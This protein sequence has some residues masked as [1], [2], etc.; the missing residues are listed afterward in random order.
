MPE[1]RRESK[2]KAFAICIILHAYL[3]LV[4]RH[5]APS[6]PSWMDVAFLIPGGSE[7]ESSLQ[8]GR[9]TCNKSFSPSRYFSLFLS[10]STFKPSSPPLDY[11]LPL[12]LRLPHPHPLPPPLSHLFFFFD[13]HTNLRRRRIIMPTDAKEDQRLPYACSCRARKDESCRLLPS[14]IIRPERKRLKEEGIGPRSLFVS[15]ILSSVP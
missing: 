2:A 6:N 11:V 12:L 13:I 7:S 8:L 1:F 4:A 10:I 15:W 3:A 14:S 9:L 5:Q